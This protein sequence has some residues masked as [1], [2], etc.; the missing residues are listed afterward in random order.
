MQ[1]CE[2]LIFG[3]HDIVHAVF[4]NRLEHYTLIKSLAWNLE[5][6]TGIESGMVFTLNP[7]PKIFTHHHY[8]YQWWDFVTGIF[9]P[10]SL[11]TNSHHGGFLS[12][13][14]FAG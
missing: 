13:W 9:P 6:T 5:M 8:H 11:L 1:F 14:E 7:T 4:V 10:Y 12:W 3:L 2:S